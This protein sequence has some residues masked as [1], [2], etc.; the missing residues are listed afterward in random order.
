[1]TSCY[2][3]PLTVD[4][5]GQFR[6]GFINNS[7]NR[8]KS[9]LYASR[10]LSFNG[11]D[12]SGSF[13]VPRILATSGY[14]ENTPYAPVV[15]ISN[16]DGVA[17]VPGS[18]KAIDLSGNYQISGGSARKDQITIRDIGNGGV[19]LG[20][21]TTANSP[22][23]NSYSGNVLIFNIAG[24][25]LTAGNIDASLG[26]TA[27]QSGRASGNITIYNVTGDVTI[28][29]ATATSASTSS[30]QAGSLRIGYDANDVPSA[31][32]GNITV[33][34]SIDLHSTQS[35]S[36]NGNLKLT[37]S[38]AKSVI[39]LASLDLSKVSVAVI[40]PGSKCILKGDLLG[41]STNV[42]TQTQLRMPAGKR[43]IYY[44]GLTNNAYL[45][46][47][48]YALA[49]VDGTPA[50]GGVLMPY[51]SPGTVITLK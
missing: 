27:M 42:T 34:G 26:T 2:T 31:I 10:D 1:M 37:A 4:H 40:A 12:K 15:C 21:L 32:S 17:I 11:G 22:L 3:G 5:V 46:G 23:F 13:T 14:E 25:G 16:Y 20:D 7:C 48:K 29:S 18:G 51:A 8:T 41:F 50:A 35:A 49:S 24:G 38:G 39:T 47:G 6:S 33:T 43:M 19:A 45:M 36:Y 28:A 44:P 9:S 30:T